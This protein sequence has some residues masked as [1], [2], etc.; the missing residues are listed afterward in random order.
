MNF[1]KKQSDLDFFFLRLINEMRICDDFEPDEMKQ[2]Y[3]LGR[4]IYNLRINDTRD[5]KLKHF[6]NYVIGRHLLQGY[7]SEQIRF[8]DNMSMTDVAKEAKRIL[9]ID[10]NENELIH[11]G[12]GYRSLFKNF[13]KDLQKLAYVVFGLKENQLLFDNIP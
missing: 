8:E 10:E 12:K 2:L 3:E 5:G 4:F 13:N 7:E 1:S 11:L 9:L 6:L